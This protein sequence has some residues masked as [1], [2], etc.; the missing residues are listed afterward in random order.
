MQIQVPAL[1][2][3]RSRLA[4]SGNPC[5]DSSE[6]AALEHL[7]ITQVEWHTLTLQHKL[8]EAMNAFLAVLDG[9]TSPLIA[10][11]NRA[12]DQL[13]LLPEVIAR[14]APVPAIASAKTR[15]PAAAVGRRW[16]T[17]AGVGGRGVTPRR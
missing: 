13:G 2:A 17:S 8:G 16:M 10:V 12:V 6:A 7:H 11:A 14:A 9:V 3:M 15:K 5:S 1:S 4:F